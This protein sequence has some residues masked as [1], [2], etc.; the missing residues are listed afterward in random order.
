[1][2]RRYRY[3]VAL[4]RERHFGRAAADG[5]VGAILEG[6]EARTRAAITPVGVSCGV[7]PG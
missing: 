4:A 1:M 5:E 3:L 6:R 7:G 2:L